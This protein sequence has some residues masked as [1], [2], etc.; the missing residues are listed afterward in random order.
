ML[1]KLCS[2]FPVSLLATLTALCLCRLLVYAYVTREVSRLLRCLL[3]G[4]AE[5]LNLTSKPASERFR[6]EDA[7]GREPHR[8]GSF[9]LFL[10]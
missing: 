8:E 4:E 7:V 5:N 3:R 1:L 9:D 2:H 10:L 6:V